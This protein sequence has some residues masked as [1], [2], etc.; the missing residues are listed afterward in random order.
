[1]PACCFV[2]PQNFEGWRA[3]LDERWKLA[4]IDEGVRVGLGDPLRYLEGLA[5]SY[6]LSPNE[7]LT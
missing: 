6:Q 5:K 3:R 2:T 7:W 1:M 4:K